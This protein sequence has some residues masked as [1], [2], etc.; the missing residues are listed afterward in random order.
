MTDSK[1]IISPSG[2]G[3]APRGADLDDFI[4]QGEKWLISDR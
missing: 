4:F 3:P 1:I 2:E